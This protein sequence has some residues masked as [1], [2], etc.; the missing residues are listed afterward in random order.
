VKINN[1]DIVGV[2]ISPDEAHTPLI[3]DADAML[4]GAMF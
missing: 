4:P 2:S 1:L 3:V